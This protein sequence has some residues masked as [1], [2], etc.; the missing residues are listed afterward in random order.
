MLL[1]ATL[2]PALITYVDAPLLAPLD[3]LFD[4][5]GIA[6]CL[7]G[8]PREPRVR[9]LTAALTWGLADSIAARAG[10]LFFGARAA[11]TMDMTYIRMT[12]AS[13]VG[14]VFFVALSAA[15]VLLLNSESAAGKGTAAAMVF[16]VA[17][18]EAVGAL[19][20]GEDQEADSW[21][22][23]IVRLAI[24]LVVACV[25]WVAL[26]SNANGTKSDEHA[27]SSTKTSSKKKSH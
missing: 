6:Y 5:A 20:A 8:L 2:Y 25:A 10:P 11:S 14:V 26:G 4:V 7:P 24:S 12:A 1:Q 21:T 17:S 19:V 18:S 13:N 27:K 9:A 16:A 15:L 23:Q 3:R 22:A